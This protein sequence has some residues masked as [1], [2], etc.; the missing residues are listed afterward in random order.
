[1]TAILSVKKYLLQLRSVAL[2]S[3]ISWNS[4]V[5]SLSLAVLDK[6]PC[7]I[8][9]MLFCMPQLY[10]HEIFGEWVLV[11]PIVVSADHHDQVVNLWILGYVAPFCTRSMCL[12]I[13]SR[14][15]DSKIL[16]TLLEKKVFTPPFEAINRYGSN[17]CASSGLKLKWNVPVTAPQQ[18]PTLRW[19][20]FHSNAMWERWSPKPQIRCSFPKFCLHTAASSKQQ[21]HI[22]SQFS[23]IVLIMPQTPPLGIRYEV[24]ALAHEGMW[25][26]ATGDFTKYGQP[27]PWPDPT[28]RNCPLSAMAVKVSLVC[29]NSTVFLRIDVFSQCSE[30][31][32]SINPINTYMHHWLWSPLTQ[33]MAW[34]LLD[35]KPLPEIIL[36][37]N[38]LYY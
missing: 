34:C 6:C 14:L 16:Y 32:N 29:S 12:V 4:L 37:H 36:F 2:F 10:P 25:Q 13:S 7:R 33:V 24:L 27:D 3:I 35:A 22:F 38:Q 21:L 8:Y 19:P 28:C 17:F 20:D 9:L 26:S 5:F 1:M 23:L 30:V 18:N 31:I 11:N 15:R